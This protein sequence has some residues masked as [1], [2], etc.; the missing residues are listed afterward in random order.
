LIDRDL[1]TMFSV[2]ARTL[3][4]TVKR[5]IQ[6]FPDDFIFHLSQKEFEEWKSQIVISGSNLGLRL[7]RRTKNA[8]YEKHLKS[9]VS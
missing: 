9:V 5:N 6:K 2:E 8:S 7:G 4:Q 1:A 3:N